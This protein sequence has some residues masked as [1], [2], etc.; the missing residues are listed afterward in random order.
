MRRYK[1][2]HKANGEL[3]SV[4]ISGRLSIIYEEGKWVSAHQTAMAKGYGCTVFTN[5]YRALSMG[6]DDD[7]LA[8]VHCQGIMKLPDKLCIGHGSGDILWLQWAIDTGNIDG[9]GW[10][11][12]TQMFAKVKVVKLADHSTMRQLAEISENFA[13]YAYD[14]NDCE[15]AKRKVRRI[16]K[17]VF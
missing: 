2:L 9:R 3:S 8:L 11:P 15:N 17:D 5:L 4:I 7:V 12:D 6:S 16:L 10:P 13:L 14:F 1:L